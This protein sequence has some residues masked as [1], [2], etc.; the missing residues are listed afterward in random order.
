MCVLVIKP[1]WLLFVNES[2]TLSSQNHCKRI[3]L[4]YERKYKRSIN[5]QLMTYIRKLC[6]KGLRS[7]KF[8]VFNH[9]YFS[10]GNE[11]YWLGSSV[12]FYLRD[13]LD[14]ILIDTDT[15]FHILFLI[16]IQLS[17]NL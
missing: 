15:D 6:L 13:K 14:G 3:N 10:Q 7:S 2:V 1:N 11:I 9:F 5:L 8:L 16:C 4:V 17:L 12:R